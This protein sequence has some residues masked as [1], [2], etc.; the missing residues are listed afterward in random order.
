MPLPTP[1]D[2]GAATPAPDAHDAANTDP[3][4]RE[5]RALADRGHLPAARD[6]LDAY[7]ARSPLSV[8][9]YRLLSHVQHELGA[10]DEYEATLQRILYLDPRSAETYLRLGLLY[11]ARGR[12]EQARRAFRNALGEAAENPASDPEAATRLAAL[13][14]RYLQE[15]DR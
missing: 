1:A 2:R 14:R 5:A 9:G 7:L 10:L 8:A 11:R 4:L 3:T 15:S 12:R 13:A 6:L